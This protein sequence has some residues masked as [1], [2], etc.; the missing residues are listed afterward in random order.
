MTLLYRKRKLRDDGESE[1]E[2]LE[3]EREDLVER[4]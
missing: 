2:K 3:R 1:R 4:S